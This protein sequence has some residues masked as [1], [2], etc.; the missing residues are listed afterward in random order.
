MKNAPK[1]FYAVLN[2]GLGHASRS[3]PLIREFR[4]RG[5]QVLVGSTG[6]ALEF[7]KWEVPGATFLD[8]PAYD[9]QYA[10]NGYLLPRL[11]AQFPR[12]LKKIHDETR[13]CKQVVRRHAPDLI[14]SDHC[15]GMYHP[16]VRSYFLSHQ[17]YFEMPGGLQMFSALG[18]HF[19]F[20]YHRAYQAIIIPDLKGERGGLLSGRLSRTP[21]NRHHYFYTGLLSSIEKSARPADIDVLVSI[22][23]PEP[24]RTIFE[25]KVLAQIGGVPGKKVVLLGKSESLQTR[26]PDPSLQVRSHAPREEIQELFNRARLIV[27]RPGYSTLMELAE[28]GKP[29]LL[30]PTP[31]QTEQIYLARRMTQMGWFFSVPQDSLDLETHLPRAADFPGLSRPGATQQS[32]Q[33]LFAQWIEPYFGTPLPRGTPGQ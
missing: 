11:A 22:S 15:Y 30:V 13:F 26:R 5:W 24:Q 14:I 33:R 16:A 6:R 3:L 10:A 8:T 18:G 25:Q 23:G 4:K 31:G 21:G 27:S 17:I 7:L 20:R 19:N 12:L 9:L 28:L 32:V 2:M 1:V 29:A